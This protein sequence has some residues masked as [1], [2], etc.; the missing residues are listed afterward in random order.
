MGRKCNAVQDILAMEVFVS[1]IQSLL[2][3]T[4][5]DLP[6]LSLISDCLCHVFALRSLGLQYTH[7]CA[8]PLTVRPWYDGVSDG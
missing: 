8:S 3:V 4:D 5:K 7:V 6:W 1:C 2:P